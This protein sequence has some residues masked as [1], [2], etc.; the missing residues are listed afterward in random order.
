M[1]GDWRTIFVESVNLLHGAAYFSSEYRHFGI[2][3]QGKGYYKG[4]SL[5]GDRLLL[6]ATFANHRHRKDF[7]F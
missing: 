6:M 2:Q 7:D 4:Y 5:F 3:K 1:D